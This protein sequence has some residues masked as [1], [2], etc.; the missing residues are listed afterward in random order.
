MQSQNYQ[1]EMKWK[2]GREETLVGY[3]ELRLAETLGEKKET[4]L[5]EY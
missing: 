4:W 5:I 3:H 1:N 2:E